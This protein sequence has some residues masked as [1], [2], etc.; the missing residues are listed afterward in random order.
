MTVYDNIARTYLKMLNTLSRI[1]TI[2]PVIQ[3]TPVKIVSR[4][5]DF[6]GNKKLQIL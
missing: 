4:Q 6:L 3:N 1:L 5:E 2:F